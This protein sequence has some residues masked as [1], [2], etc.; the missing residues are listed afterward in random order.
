MDNMQS[1][2]NTPHMS[3]ESSEDVADTTCC[4]I[5]QKFPNLTS[6]DDVR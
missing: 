5:M 3:A 2:L 1:T 6:Y 4:G